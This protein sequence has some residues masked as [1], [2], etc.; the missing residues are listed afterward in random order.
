MAVRSFYA[1]LG[2]IDKITSK[3]QPITQA[4]NSATVDRTIKLNADISGLSQKVANSG[5][6]I[7]KHIGGGAKIAEGAVKGVGKA[8]ED[9]TTGA[10]LK[11]I[12]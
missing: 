9:I 12:Q 4:I 8:T 2:I 1:E 3:L 5:S 6:A 7:Q 11:L 10:L